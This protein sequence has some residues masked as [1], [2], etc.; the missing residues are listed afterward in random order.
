MGEECGESALEAHIQDPVRLVQNCE[1][2]V[3]NGIGG[4]SDVAYLT[5]GDYHSRILSSGP[6]AGAVVLVSRPGCSCATVGP[7]HPSGSCPR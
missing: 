5:F 4:D 2:G 6:C 7:S 1:S 3:G